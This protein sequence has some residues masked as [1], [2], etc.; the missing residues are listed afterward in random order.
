MKLSPSTT[1]DHQMQRPINFDLHIAIERLV[2]RL[3]MNIQ[4][5]IKVH[6]LNENAEPVFLDVA[7][8]SVVKVIVSR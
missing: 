7:Y 6:D 1:Q 3:Y 2:V 5:Y 4:K 8:T